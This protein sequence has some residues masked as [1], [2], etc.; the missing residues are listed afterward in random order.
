MTG[1]LLGSG[2]D[3]NLVRAGRD[4]AGVVDILGNLKP[5]RR[6]PL[7][8]TLKKQQVGILVEHLGA[9]FFPFVEVK[10]AQIV[11]IGTSLQRVI[12]DVIKDG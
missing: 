9:A 7:G 10:A 11:E 3:D 1:D 5:E 6:L 8:L 2:T 12:V 4:T